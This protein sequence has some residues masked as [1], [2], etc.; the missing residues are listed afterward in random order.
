MSNPQLGFKSIEDWTNFI[1]NDEGYWPTLQPAHLRRHSGQQAQFNS[2]SFRN[3]RLNGVTEA[4]GLEP[5]PKIVNDKVERAFT[6]MFQETE[7]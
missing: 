6:I 4:G 1:D 5:L 7:V 3:G 2:S